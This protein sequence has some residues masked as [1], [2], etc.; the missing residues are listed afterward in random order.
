[1]KGR[2]VDRVDRRSVGAVAMLVAA[3][4]A[5]TFAGSVTLLLPLHST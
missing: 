2:G 1:M 5:G 3:A 4:S